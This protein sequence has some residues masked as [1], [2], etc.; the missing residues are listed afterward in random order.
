MSRSILLVEDDDRELELFSAAFERMGLAD[1][2]HIEKNCA[3]ALAYLRA[4]AGEKA[5]LTLPRLALIDLRIPEHDGAELLAAIRKDQRL[6]HLPVVM[7]TASED[8]ADVLR[9]YRAR[10]NAYVVKPRHLA[11]IVESL[12]SITNFWLKINKMPREFA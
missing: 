12:R 7:Y 10:A 6:T 11:G 2:V 5:S 9:C 4:C 8:K 3:Q 1:E